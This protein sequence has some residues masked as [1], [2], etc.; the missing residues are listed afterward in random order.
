M[1]QYPLC[2]ISL[3]GI[4]PALLIIYFVLRT[5]DKYFKHNMFFMLFAGGIVLGTIA[6]VFHLMLDPFFLSSVDLAFL[7]YILGFSLL[8]ELMKF[9]ILYYK[10]FR[11]DYETTYYGFALGLGI[12]AMIITG[13]VYLGVL[14]DPGGLEPEVLVIP[15][16]LFLSIGIV[17]MNGA[18]GA[19]IGYGSSI[20]VRWKYFGLALLLHMIFNTF[21]LG[22]WW[23]GY[24]SGVIFT[25]I[26]MV[27]GIAL[28][29][30]IH[31][32][33]IPESLPPDLKRK[34]RREMR[35][36]LKSPGKKRIRGSSEE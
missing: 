21:L 7:G 27:F 5:Y 3:F 28:V 10:S 20:Q 35:R 8:E 25:I 19:I 34:R 17:G 2:L 16:A 23:L 30:Y 22:F 6:F 15:S 1:F 33:I 4:V 11:G 36:A 24:P 18:T 13:L 26:V 32:E 12:G 9:I 31:E 14:T 29:Y